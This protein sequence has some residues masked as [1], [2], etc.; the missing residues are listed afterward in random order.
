MKESTVLK[1][2]ESELVYEEVILWQGK[3]STTALISKRDMIII[4]LAIIWS[5]IAI[6]WEYMAIQ[7]DA[8]F[9]FKLWGI[10]FIFIGIYLLIGRFLVTY[11]KR[12]NTIYVLTNRR[13]FIVIKNAITSTRYERMEKIYKMVRA[14]GSG[15]IIFKS[16]ENPMLPFL[17]F[18]FLFKEEDSNGF[19]EIA[20]VETVYELMMEQK[21]GRFRP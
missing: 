19:M 15:S 10:P 1:R 8:P 4:P 6:Y 12:K 18:A 16:L 17:R 9:V 20:H 13:A 5:T 2:L 21:H 14:D 7:T 3:P 11:D